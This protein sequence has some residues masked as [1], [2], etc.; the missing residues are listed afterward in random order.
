MD[1][2]KYKGDEGERDSEG[3]VKFND[4]PIARNNQNNFYG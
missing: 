2:K 3:E 1:D 4:F